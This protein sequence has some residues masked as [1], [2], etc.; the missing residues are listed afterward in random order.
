MNLF[1]QR[2]FQVMWVGQLATIFGNRFS[3][4][5]IP[6]IVLQL[7]GSPWHAALVVVCSQVAPLVLSLPVSNWIENKK[8]R[9]VAL[10]AEA[11][12]FMTMSALVVLV[13]L[14]MLT[15]WT[16]AGSLLVLG[17]AGLFFRISFG[18]MVPGVVGRQNLMKAH[19]SF[20]GADAV[21]TLIGPFLAGAVL[22][23]YG[24]G[25]V[26]SVDAFTYLVSFLGILLLSY[27]EPVKKKQTN[28][29]E[30]K[31]NG[32]SIKNITYLFKNEY[33]R[34]ISFN[35][36]KLNFTTTAVTLT[37][38]IYTSQTLGLSEWQTGLVLSAAGAGNL[39]GVFLLQRV[40]FVQ[41]RYLFG[42][43]MGVSGAGIVFLLSTETLPF[44]ML[45]MFL[46]DGALS[47]AFVVNG[48][49]RQAV[50]PDHYLARIGGGGILIAGL[51][52]IMGNLFAGG[53]SEWIGPQIALGLCALLLFVGS[54]RSLRFRKGNVSV[55]E[56]KPMDFV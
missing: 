43:L 16:L 34:F 39:V 21:S 54:I 7:T 42:I 13:F 47:M 14:D 44:L 37:V 22:T 3:E 6:L 49:A 18:V 30:R 33:Q 24:I 12:S 23:F 8:K 50:T 25:A 15:I 35:H 1:K 17:A 52:A 5:A 28:K 19:N 27:K 26:L 32:T 29:S 38:I 48:S 2:N 20:E 41:W 51:V 10:F 36:G 4:I 46:F 55:R 9:N 40:S 11:V 56:L 53:I 45:G 31:T